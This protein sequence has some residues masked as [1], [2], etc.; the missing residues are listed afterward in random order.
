MKKN[1]KVKYS[2]LDS[3]Q[4]LG[5]NKKRNLLREFKSLTRIKKSSINEL[6]RVEGISIK[7]ANQIKNTL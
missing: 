2:I 6:C 1:K 5:P 7:I 3:I 4:G